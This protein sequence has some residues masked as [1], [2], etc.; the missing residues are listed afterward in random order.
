MAI[1]IVVAM[2]EE[3]TALVKVLRGVTR[4][5]RDGCWLYRGRLA[6]RE[7]CI[8]EGGMGTTAASKAAKLLL[9]EC[10]PQLLI[11]AGYCGAVRPGPQTGDLVVCSRL[12]TADQERVQELPLPGGE[13]VAAR[14]AAELQRFG[15]RAWQGSFITTCSITTKSAISERLPEDMVHPVLEMESAAV[16]LAAV[17]AGLPFVGLRAVSDDSSEELQF[18]LDEICGPDGQVA[19]L[20]VLGLLMRRPGLLGQ[21]LRLAAGSAKAGKSLGKGMELIVPALLK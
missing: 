21:F 19:V 13:Q 15:L 17:G 1:G 16:A 5:Q 18:S 20:R 7:I 8:V 3:R 14:L 9:A 10:A 2:P 6:E 12:L 11:S 4:L